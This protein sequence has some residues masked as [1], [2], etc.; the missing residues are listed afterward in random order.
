MSVNGP[1]IA[2]LVKQVPDVNEIT[3]DP[4]KYSIDDESCYAITDYR[5]A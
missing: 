5:P 3:I 2:V 4:A 1:N